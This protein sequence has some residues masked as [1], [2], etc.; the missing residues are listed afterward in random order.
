M[1]K[2]SYWDISSLWLLANFPAPNTRIKVKL[3]SYFNQTSPEDIKLCHL[4]V[5]VLF[6]PKK[7]PQSSP[8]ILS[9]KISDILIPDM[10]V[11]RMTGK[12]VILVSLMTQTVSSDFSD[13]L[14][15]Y[16]LG[17]GLASN[18]NSFNCCWYSCFNEL[19]SILITV[20]TMTSIY[21]MKYFV[22]IPLNAWS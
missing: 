3:F 4:T 15:A 8:I 5:L 21:N 11:T 22:R 12:V 14:I 7:K 2:W 18:L 13:S 10:L 1:A 19:G 20:G 16:P 6:T 17:N 9:I